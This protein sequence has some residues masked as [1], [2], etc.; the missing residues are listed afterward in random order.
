VNFLHDI[1]VQNYSQDLSNSQWIDIHH[2][3]HLLEDKILKES[4]LDHVYLH[5]DI[6]FDYAEKS[7]PLITKFDRSFLKHAVSS[8]EPGMCYLSWSEIGKTPY[9]YWADGEP[10]DIDRLCKLAKPWVFLK[11]C[12]QIALDMPNHINRKMLDFETWFEPFRSRWC[13]HWGLNDWQLQELS[14]IIP[15]GHINSEDIDIMKS[16]F[17]KLNY[18]TRITL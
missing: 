5:N 17:K 18:P 6:W 1:Y 13:E 7:G 3:I 14:A 8:A 9:Q 2:L 15:I 11:P 10:A 12:M 16:K 4:H